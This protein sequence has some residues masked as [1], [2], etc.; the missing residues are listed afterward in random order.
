MTTHL[1]VFPTPGPLELFAQHFD[2]LFPKRS[3][4]QAFR[5]Y[6]AG[7]L[8]PTER[9]KMLTAL[10]HTEPI[11]GA[12]AAPAQCLQWFLSESTW[13]AEAVNPCHL[14][15]PARHCTGCR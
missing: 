11:V 2:S 4:R 7:L 12:Q 8:L 5:A 9:T 1:P 6:L 3:Q 15:C 13:D 14:A 10:A